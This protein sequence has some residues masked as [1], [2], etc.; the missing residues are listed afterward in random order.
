MARRCPE[1]RGLYLPSNSIR[2]GCRA[3]R[4]QPAAAA[5][6]PGAAPGLEASPGHEPFPAPRAGH[7]GELRRLERGARPGR[8]AGREPRAQPA[9]PGRS[10][11]RGA[12]TRWSRRRRRRLPF[13]LLFQLRPLHP[14]L[15]QLRLQLPPPS[16]PPPPFS[17]PLS[18]PSS[19]SIAR[20]TLSREREVNKNV[21]PPPPNRHPGGS[22]GARRC[23]G[24]SRGGS[25]L[26][27]PAAGHLRQAAGPGLERGM[28]CPE[29]LAGSAGSVRSCPGG[30][31][32]AASLGRGG[33]R[34]QAALPA[35]VPPRVPPP[36]PRP[37]LHGGRSVSIW[38]GP[39]AEQRSA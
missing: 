39:D 13:P 1:P 31:G 19:S 33:S 38:A 15:L 23:P 22:G 21:P 4:G 20:A 18:P 11:L 25:P 8:A 14:P 29:S 27:S 9:R 10:P 28:L 32:S 16:P 7:R 2:G 30:R 37:G 6:A 17:P 12:R 3:R 34:G 5:T 26:A 35:Q 36:P 24:G